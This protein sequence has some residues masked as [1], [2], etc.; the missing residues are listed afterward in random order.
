MTAFLA[1]SCLLGTALWAV[2]WLPRHRGARRR[3][4]ELFPNDTAKQAGFEYRWLVQSPLSGHGL[5]RR[6]GKTHRPDQ[7]V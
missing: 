6:Y 3:A 1:A 7:D 5:A 4:E 2:I